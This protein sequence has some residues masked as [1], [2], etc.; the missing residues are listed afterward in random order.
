MRGFFL[1]LLL[2]SGNLTAQV[3]L[4][5]S[6]GE[7]SVNQLYHFRTTDRELD[8]VEIQQ[9]D[10]DP[11][12]PSAV[13]SIGF[14]RGIHWFRLNVLNQSDISTWFLEV[15]FP[16]LDHLEV[17][18]PD[19]QGNWSLQ[20]TGDYYPVSSRPVQHRNYVFPINIR[21]DITTPV[22]IKLESTS[23]IQLPLTIWS[24]VG[25]R[26]ALQVDEF[27]H[28]LFYGV[29]I[30]MILYNLLL[31][32][33]I[34]DRST[35]Y[36]ILALITALNVIAF[37][38]GYGFF[39][40]YPENPEWNF[41]F[42]SMSAP[43]FILSSVGLTRSFLDLKRFSVKLDQALVA[44]AVV[45]VVAALATMAWSEVVS[46]LPLNVLGVIDFS[47]ILVSAVFCVVS[48]FRPA[49]LYLITWAGVMLVGSLVAMRNLGLISA[50]WLSYEF[51]YIGGVLQTLLLSLALV[52]RISE[53]KRGH[54]EAQERQLKMETEAKE[55]L[56]K[57]VTARTEEIVKKHLLL[58]ETNAVKD[59]LFSV[60]SHD[61]KGPL[62]SL[63][64][65]MD[66]VQLGALSKAEQQDLMKRIGEQLNLT[67]DFLDNL[68]QWSRTQLHG[69]SFVPNKEKFSIK[70]LVD[71]C[72]RLL[73]PEFSHK[74]I[75]L[76]VKI[77]NDAT[78]VADKN[79]IETVLRNLVS[80]ALK[81]TK[82]GGKVH[83]IVSKQDDLVRVD[84][85]DNGIGI[86]ADNLESL[87]TL[88]GVT[89]AGTREEKGTGIGLVVCKEF[90]ERNG[91]RIK[92][93]SVPGSGS[94]FSFTLLT[95]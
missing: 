18:S 73:A 52:D 36:Y 83:L 65:I 17:Y 55:N 6:A 31:Y 88:H 10:L 79:M 32:F 44:V 74:S 46:Y 67:S 62:K 30:I 94:M 66:G 71:L 28:G 57:E 7:Y 77:H 39:Y 8:I 33:S 61:L 84:V 68:L 64:G 90:V 12:E 41:L 50:E 78:V 53:L 89:T 49:R 81:F 45:T 91:G 3:I 21:K 25:F 42:A 26:N 29:M 56:E 70:E 15:G 27:V 43:L 75:A 76:D 4:K 72:T 1:I 80:N 37:I 47:L 34:R 13:R 9:R 11:L 59:K 22:I 24:P 63:K 58:E 14:D 87:F 92:V 95:R 60:V 35:I 38:H 54:N 5:N 82:P 85:R 48:G 51:L 16:Q 86:P 2:V 23:S 20:F 69:E 93:T 19:P 40:L